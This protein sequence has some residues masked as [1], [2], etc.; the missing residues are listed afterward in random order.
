[1][2]KTAIYQKERRC[3][4]CE[5]SIHGRS[6]KIFCGIN[7]KNHYHSEVR[8]ITKTISAETVKIINKNWAILT[9]MMTKDY[10][11]VTVK[12]LT[13]QRLGFDF[14]AITSVHSNHSFINFG[15]YNYIYYITKYDKVV[16]MRNKEESII[17]PFLFKRMLKQF[18][19]LAI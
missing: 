2:C 5:K 12:K 10:N 16:I 7:C 13:L 19:I 17:T 4:V 18:P 3:L 8:K 1:M 14:G 6:D 9:S 15:I 11:Q